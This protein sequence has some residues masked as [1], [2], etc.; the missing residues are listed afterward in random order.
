[1]K[2]IDYLKRERIPYKVS[3]ETGGITLESS[4]WY[5]Y[6]T[7]SNLPDN[8]TIRGSLWSTMPIG[9]KLPKNLDVR[10]TLS[11]RNTSIRKFP[12]CLKVVHKI[13]FKDYAFLFRNL[14]IDKEIL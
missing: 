2:L 7:I 10:M 3:K 9:A 1:M 8:F 11:L 13:Y 12:K 5:N 14:T 4:F 6:R